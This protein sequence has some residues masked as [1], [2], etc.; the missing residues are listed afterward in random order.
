MDRASAGEAD[1]RVERRRAQSY[2][3][4][5]SGTSTSHRPHHSYHKSSLLPPRQV[6]TAENGL[7]SNS[8][9]SNVREKESTSAEYEL[10]EPAAELLLGGKAHF[11]SSARPEEGGL[12]DEKNNTKSA[13][14]LKAPCSDDELCF[15]CMGSFTK[16]SP[17]VTLPCSEACNNAPVHAKCIYEWGERQKNVSSCPL[18]RSKLGEVEYTPPDLLRSQQLVMFGCR[19]A[20]ITLPLPRKVG[21]VRCFL[22]AEQVGRQGLR[23]TVWKLYLQ[24]PPK[25]RYPSGPRPDTDSPKEGDRL[26]LVARKR[27]KLRRR[28][29]ITLDEEGKDFRRSSV[30]YV[31]SLVSSTLGLEHSIVAPFRETNSTRKTSR[32]A[33]IQ[34]GF[35][36]YTQNRIGRS[37]GPRRMELAL[38]NVSRPSYNENAPPVFYH[39]AVSSPSS[40]SFDSA[41][42]S[43]DETSCESQVVDETK[44]WTTKVHRPANRTQTLRSLLSRGSEAMLGDTSIIYGSNVEPYWLEQI[45]AYSLDFQGRVTL[46]S[47][48]NFQLVAGNRT[49]DII[50]QFGKVISL[51]SKEIYTMD[52]QWP[53]SPLQAFGICLSACNRKLAC[54]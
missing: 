26:L 8:S 32:N 43:D 21:I 5:H 10:L 28:I 53:L 25:L 6:D 13:K 44:K 52:V 12:Y 30:Q 47:N 51:Q 37:V 23:H 17:A 35:V 50:L 41:E 33:Y 40:L 29:D 19:K 7:S 24:A 45:G 9:S 31:G 18:C 36:K 20:F 1:H 49:N 54:A 11:D 4:T 27:G 14:G 46:P 34:L 16:R 42:E 48:K 2:D 3:G 22:I 39:D 15:I 38:P